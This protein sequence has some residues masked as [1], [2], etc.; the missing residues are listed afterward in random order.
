MAKDKLTGELID[1]TPIPQPA[2][3]DPMDVRTPA[4]APKTPELDPIDQGMDADN[5][6]RVGAQHALLQS[7][8]M[9]AIQDQPEKQAQILKLNDQLGFSNVVDKDTYAAASQKQKLQSIDYRKLL[10]AHPELAKWLTF[11]SNA[12]IAHDEVPQLQAWSEQAQRLGHAPHDPNGILPDGYMFQKDGTIRGPLSDQPGIKPVI[13]KSLDDVRA[14][15]KREDS[16]RSVDE[17][18]AKT[19]R[20]VLDQ[21]W[22]PSIYAALGGSLIGSADAIS[23]VSGSHDTDSFLGLGM[24]DLKQGAQQIGAASEELN[25]GITGTAGRLVGQLIGDAPLYLL[26]GE[27]AGLADLALTLRGVRAATALPRTPPSIYLEDVWKTALT[28]SPIAARSGIETG[29]EHGP[30]YGSVDFLINALGPAAFGSKFGL[31]NAI[32]P[33]RETAAAA[34][35]WAGV[36]QRL[37]VHAGSQGGIMAATELGNA[38]HEYATGVDPDA[39][40]RENLLPR[41]GQAAA[42]GGILS[43]AFQLPGQVGHQMHAQQVAAHAAM[44]D[45]GALGRLMEASEALKVPE[46]SP[47]HFEELLQASI[48]EAQRSKFYQTEDFEGVAKAANV[49]PEQLADQMGIGAEYKKAVATGQTMVVPT[50][51]LLKWGMEHEDP[52][53]KAALL[54]AARSNAMG[55]NAN[56]AVKF[57]KETPDQLAQQKLELETDVTKAA[58]EL[59][60]SDPIF[61]DIMTK[62]E[63]AGQVSDAARTNAKLMAAFFNVQA[64]HW[65]AGAEARG[66]KRMDPLEEYEKTHFQ[67]KKGGQKGHIE[68]LDAL[69]NR[70][71]EGNVPTEKQAYGTSLTE[72]LAKR[73]LKDPKGELKKI[74]ADTL[75]DE[76]GHELELAAERAHD[77]G[78]IEDADPQTLLDAIKQE[79]AGRPVFA[80]GNR[81]EDLHSLRSGAVALAQHLASKGINIARP[82]EEIKAALAGDEFVSRFEQRAPKVDAGKRFEQMIADDPEGMAKAY[83]ELPGTDGGKIVSSDL[84]KELSPDFRQDRTKNAAL[85]HEASSK[86]ADRLYRDALAKAPE[87]EAVLL[88]GGGGG[89]GKTAALEAVPH[90][91]SD[92]TFDGTMATY[93]SSKRRIEQALA[94]GR[95]VD[96]NYVYRPIDLAMQGVISR[97]GRTG[98]S[99]PAKAVAESHYQSQRTVMRLADEFKGDDRV[100]IVVLDNSGKIDEV[101]VHEVDWLRDRM[102]PSVE[103]VHEQ[104]QRV[105]EDARAEGRLSPELDQALS[106]VDGGRD[107]AA[108]RVVRG[109][110]EARREEEPGVPGYERVSP[111]LTE[112]ER[113]STNNSTAAKLVEAFKNL[114]SARDFAAAAKA[115]AAKRGWYRDSARAITDVF[116]HQDAPRFTALLAALSPQ[117]SVELNLL[118]AVATW[119]NWLA[120]GRPT[121]RDAI[122]KILGQSVQGTKGVDSVLPAW[123]N[124]AERALKAADPSAVTLS[125][126]KVDSF[127]RN[128]RGNVEE[129]TNDAWMA[130]F[131]HIDQVLFSGSLNVAGTNP[132]KGFGYKAMSAKV[133]QA[134]EILTRETGETWTPAEVQETVWSWTKALYEAASAKGETRSERELVKAGAITDEKIAATPDFATQLTHDAVLKHLEDAG[135][136]SALDRLAEFDRSR[137]GAAS[138]DVGQGGARAGGDDQRA[139]LRSAKRLEEL[140]AE[141]AAASD[142]AGERPA[143]RGD[144]ERPAGEQEGVERL[145][146]APKSSNP[147]PAAAL[148]AKAYMEATGRRYAPP[149]QYVRVLGDPG[150]EARGKAIADAYEAMEHDP[151]D[152]KVKA[153][154]A[155]LARETIAQYDAMIAA[156]HKVEAIPAG[157][158]NPYK[159]SADMANDAGAGHSWYFRTEHGFGSGE[160]RGNPLLADSG[161]VDASGNKM[162]VND[163]FRVVH[164]YYGHAVHGTSFGANGEENAWRAH[165]SMYS[166]KARAAM[167]TETR[168]QNSWVNFGPHG[169]ANR[170]D[171]SKTVY[172]EQKTGL[173]PGWASETGTTKLHQGSEEGPLGSL[174]FD[175]SGHFTM[176]LNGNANLSTVAHEAGHFWLEK[177]GDFAMREGAPQQMRDDYQ[178]ILEFVG[179]GTHEVK[180]AMMAE[181]TA[182][183]ARISREG[184]EPTT[185]EKR[186]LEILAEPHEKFARAIEQYLMEG[187]APSPELRGAFLRFRTWLG[188]IYKQLKSLVTLTPE[189][190]GIFDRMFATDEAIEQ[191]QK[192]LGTSTIFKDQ[193]S[194]GMSDERWARYLKS[195]QNE[196][197]RSQANVFGKAMETL[198]KENTR[199]FN[200][201]KDKFVATAT[202]LVRARPVN[203]AVNEMVHRLD[204]NGNPIKEV[205]RISRADVVKNY[206]SIAELPRGITTD[207]GGMTLENAAYAYGY[208]S[209][210]KFWTDLANYRKPKEQIDEMVDGMV[211][212]AHPELSPEAMHEAAMDAVHANNAHADVLSQESAALAIHALK[213][214]IP[215]EQMKQIAERMIDETNHLDVNPKAH[216]RAEIRA[217]DLSTAAFLKN[218]PDYTEAFLHK[219]RQELSHAL[220]RAAMEAVELM[221]KNKTLIKR[222]SKYETRQKIGH[223]GGFVVTGKNG[224]RLIT[225]SAAEA[226]ALAAEYEGTIESYLQAVDRMLDLWDNKSI[227]LDMDYGAVR[228]F[229]DE[230]AAINFQARDAFEV[231]ANGKKEALSEAIADAT[232]TQKEAAKGGVVVVPRDKH[233][234]QWQSKTWLRQFDAGNRTLAAICRSLDGEKP[235]GWHWENIVRP[236]N[237]AA[238]NETIRKIE[239][240][241]ALE[242]LY[243]T[244]GKRGRKLPVFIPAIGE[245]MNLETRIGVALNAG[246]SRNLERMKTG[247]TW[248][249]EQITAIIKTLDEKD[250]A[251]V[252]GIWSFLESKW[253]DIS[254]LRQKTEG[255]APEKRDSIPVETAFGTIDGGYY[256]ILYDKEVGA[257]A[258]T[259]SLDRAFNPI[260]GKPAAGFTK[261]TLKTT[262]MKLQYG[263]DA[264]FRHNDDTAHYLSHEDVRVN[265]NKILA[266]NMFSQSVLDRF[267]RVTY[268]ALTERVKNVLEGPRGPQNAAERAL[269][270]FRKRG[271]LATLGFNLMSSVAQVFGVPQ[272]MHRVGV[273]AYLAAEGQILAN[274]ASAE[275]SYAF[276]NSKSSFI[277]NLDREATPETAETVSSGDSAGVVR[278]IRDHAFDLMNLSVRHINTATWLAEYKTRIAAGEE[279]SRAVAL[280][281]QAV[282]DT[283]GSGQTVDKTKFQDQNELSKTLM[284]YL[285]SFT[286]TYQLLR[287]PV[288]GFSIK[289]PNSMMAAAKAALLLVTVP[290]VTQAL[291]REAVHPSTSDDKD[292][293]WWAKKLASDHLEYLMST[294]ICGR[295][296]F[297]VVST[298][299]HQG[300]PPQGTAAIRGITSAV[301]IVANAGGFLMDPDASGAGKTVRSAYMAGGLVFGLPVN[302]ADK[303]IRGLVYDS[304]EGSANPLPVMFGPPAH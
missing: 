195:I 128:L 266:N 144:V 202:R 299:M 114:P 194:S 99:V 250:I 272:S 56:E 146:G 125:G 245:H 138:E 34:G 212:A 106:G 162:L 226:H 139:L 152:P 163:V 264:L 123:I 170:A 50:H 218:P 247:D 209:A 203:I 69:L 1:P 113:A 21:H 186:R 22:F 7:S 239:N 132:G 149:R 67:V 295:E 225:A 273:G 57:Y 252:R 121:N 216:L 192:E 188:H 30:A 199:A 68:E 185:T 193:A 253:P 168:G 90:N 44:M 281:D 19:A 70:V 279:E 96:I 238:D 84:V 249:Q 150:A 228:D 58:S 137:R 130:N 47:G 278:W 8:M 9:A 224:E 169:E 131:A 259:L 72:F 270:F 229:H 64:I 210:A 230:L 42:M 220:Y 179:Y 204:R 5:E 177:M 286:R 207:E 145:E 164:D 291:F 265:L 95:R 244:W 85:V 198:R 296:M 248:T 256:P 75:I 157:G 215:Q 29:A 133:R 158:E 267:G 65:N 302:Q 27:V 153:A 17:F 36:G 275:S 87:N 172:A 120:A 73:G 231:I 111:Y 246:S 175:A 45:A 166:A 180:Q 134:A 142:A 189:V 161:R 140:R 261:A 200:R 71:R 14:K 303:I 290:A 37:M 183:Q 15:L 81:N 6:Q 293:G 214:P 287:E 32:V 156:G 174:E 74:G 298:A 301:D 297:G 93:E 39:L 136:G 28:Y 211:K 86:F 124:N 82:N 241:K 217:S 91:P 18:M 13:Y 280:A 141:R 197:E 92:V 26:G 43:T 271:S 178:K 263:F 269:A 76:K 223:A 102:Y 262:G 40:K 49:T 243:D 257:R 88:T 79:A 268:E 126:P 165:A 236:L 147:Q 251:L 33:G 52:K 24:A 167:T 208:D 233:S 112:A 283:Q 274:A 89:S 129:V 196:R 191:V 151:S 104:A 154:Y 115:G 221:A 61:Q 160:S 234:W 276:V 103:K 173:L 254:A 35:G 116:G 23:H 105:I 235:A 122:V 176:T 285:S 135:Y 2:P 300:R 205:P 41:L 190:R 294:F 48:P 148:V 100:S 288:V 240:G 258:F 62:Y 187:H 3:I 260:V 16:Q 277:R 242:A 118:N 232:Q 54:T 127:M 53:V 222:L 97:A 171:P 83:R 4:V 206:G 109:R 38:L 117:T 46:R 12:A 77:E 25:P 108:Q 181:A 119:K 184:R 94:S 11:K 201:E 284:Q 80:A 51:L 55:I 282:R 213:S 66:A 31:A 304:D 143:G 59:K 219:Q 107:Q 101:S 227:R 159:T 60:E 98:R 292:A 63:E 182:L 78:Y 10:T 289:D 155:A 255:I 237:A 110:A 20:D